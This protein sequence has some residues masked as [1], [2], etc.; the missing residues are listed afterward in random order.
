VSDDGR[1]SSN[2]ASL[3]T[4]VVA[5]VVAVAGGACVVA[6]LR[7]RKK[8]QS[9]DTSCDRT[10][11]NPTYSPAAPSD[12]PANR[13]GGYETPVT[14]AQHPR[15]SIAAYEVPVAAYEVPVAAY[16][17]PVAGSDAR[18]PAGNSAAAVYA[19][20]SGTLYEVPL[21]VAAGNNYSRL[22]ATDGDGYE[23]PS[24]RYTIAAYEVP[25]IGS[26]ARRP[27][28]DSV[29]AVYAAQSGTLYEVPLDVAAGNNYSLARELAATG[30]D[31]RRQ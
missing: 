26:H 12:L 21:E 11:V 16:E 7:R 20:Q 27:T 4:I 22:A 19:T 25:V 18:R 8:A 13:E 14:Q 15:Y 17:V 10:T 3:V 5:L 30:G 2:G 24:T 1:D 28:G 9:Y 29:A 6:L 23:T 31:G